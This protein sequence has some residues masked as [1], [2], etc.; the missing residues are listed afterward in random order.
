MAFQRQRPRSRR[1]RRR[2]SLSVGTSGRGSRR[3]LRRNARK[4]NSS[5]PEE[6]FDSRA[7]AK[8]SPTLVIVRRLGKCHMEAKLQRVRSEKNVTAISVRTRGPKTRNAGVETKAA[9]QRIPPRG[10]LNLQAKT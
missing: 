10:L 8:K 2:S 6:N 1:Q 9:R 7:P 4:L 5:R 3:R